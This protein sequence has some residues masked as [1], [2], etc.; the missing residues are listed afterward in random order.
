M[1]VA[2]GG[3]D[4]DD[5]VAD[6]EQGHIERAATK[7]EDEDRLLGVALVEAVG[8]RCRGRLVDDAAHVE[9]GDFASFLRGLA[10]GVI[11]V[12]RNGDDRISH[13]FA[14]VGLCIALELLEHEC[15]NLLG[16]E[17]LAVDLGG[18]VGTHVALDRTDRAIDV[19]DALA[20]CH[21]AG[22]NF[23]VFGEG[24]HRRGRTGAF[25]VCNNGG[26]STFEYGNNRVG[27]AEVNSDRA[28]HTS[29]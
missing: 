25:G 21:F 19:R 29:S 11:E 24:D 15:R 1:V 17:F 23:A 18:P 22:E 26:F 13:G 8:E 10:L 5:T 2:T 16:V 4:L 6:F 9:A 12:G 28:G 27:R 7:V 14:E 20:L 3:F